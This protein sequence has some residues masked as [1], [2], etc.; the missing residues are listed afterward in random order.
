M[1]TLGVFLTPAIAQAQ[2][3]AETNP[4]GAIKTDAKI[5]LANR[6]SITIDGVE[7]AS[8]AEASI[9]AR[10][11]P[12]TVVLKRGKNSSMELWAWHEAV[13]TGD[14]AAARKSA[15]LV[16]YNYDGKPVARYHLE[17]AWPSKIELQM[18]TPT[19][20]A[21]GGKIAVETLEIA[22]PGLGEAPLET[23]TLVC[24]HIQRVS[25]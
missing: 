15:S 2:I 13:R 8:F 5:G 21:G 11:K 3:T 7:I 22:H 6:F 9:N 1:V 17:N 23:V 12:A 24:D 19:Q 20:D 18:A 14:M 10:A 4:E 25:P 16:M